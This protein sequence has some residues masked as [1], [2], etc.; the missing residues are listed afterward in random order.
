LSTK[1]DFTLKFEFIGSAC[2]GKTQLCNRFAN[3]EF[4]NDYFQTIGVEFIV[5]SLAVEG[6]RVKLQLWDTA[7]QERF[8][9]ITRSFYRGS[10]AQIAVFDLT[11]NCHFNA[12]TDCCTAEETFKDA[13]QLISSEKA[14]SSEVRLSAFSS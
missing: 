4:A 10:H 5:R 1:H 11:C 14:Y 7:G 12:C 6:N 2:A 9:S 13:R 8:R 3:D